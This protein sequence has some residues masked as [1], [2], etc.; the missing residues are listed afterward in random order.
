MCT[1]Y[2][3]SF[4]SVFY[5]S[6][7]ADKKEAEDGEKPATPAEKTTEE[8]EAKPATPSKIP[9]DTTADAAPP[10]PAP[11][12]GNAAEPPKPEAG[13]EEEDYD[14]MDD[15][16][17][18]G[19]GDQASCVSSDEHLPMISSEQYNMYIRSLVKLLVGDK[20]LDTWIKKGKETSSFQSKNSVHASFRIVLFSPKYNAEF[21]RS[22]FP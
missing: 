6:I 22:F 2:Q 19:A 10:A 12:D 5:N 9:A 14:R 13:D 7:A 1:I 3:D 4:H 15:G 16:G 20:I 18:E 21:G 11:E 17:V 8:G